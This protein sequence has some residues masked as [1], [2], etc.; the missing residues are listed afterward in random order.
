MWWSGVS[1]TTRRPHDEPNGAPTTTGDTRLGGGGIRG[2]ATAHGGIDG[3]RRSANDRDDSRVYCN[4]LVLC[5][6]RL[7]S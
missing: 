4:V 3:G 1:P 6:P 5:D 2:G 7:P